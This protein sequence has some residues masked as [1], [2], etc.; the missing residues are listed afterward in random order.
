[1]GQNSNIR[2]N[3]PSFLNPVLFPKKKSDKD[4]KILGPHLGEFRSLL[5][6]SGGEG[7]GGGRGSLLGS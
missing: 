5:T 3:M 7:Y 1:M 6:D 4:K 2:N